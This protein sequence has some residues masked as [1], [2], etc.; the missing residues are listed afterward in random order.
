[1]PQLLAQL[2]SFQ[3]L[4]L[5]A[6]CLSNLGELSDHVDRK[7][8]NDGY[9]HVFNIFSILPLTKNIFSPLS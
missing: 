7:I 3:Q 1:M 2:L 6:N 9:V 4:V 5:K 8:I